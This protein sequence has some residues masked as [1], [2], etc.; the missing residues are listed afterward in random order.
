MSFNFP[1]IVLIIICV[2]STMEF[3][4]S[5]LTQRF[6]SCEFYRTSLAFIELSGV[7]GCLA[8]LT[9]LALKDLQNSEQRIYLIFSNI[10]F[11]AIVCLGLY[12]LIRL[13]IESQYFF[14]NFRLG[15]CPSISSYF[16]LV[17]LVGNYLILLLILFTGLFNSLNNCS[18]ER[19][20]YS[21]VRF[22]R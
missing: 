9:Y 2:F 14:T 21:N 19:S 1:L 7:L 6:T 18:R 17:S 12:W 13:A 5:F 11:F 20:S 16:I 8:S 4:G 15:F 10:Y 3:I 22:V